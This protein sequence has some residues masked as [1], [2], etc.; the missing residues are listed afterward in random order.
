MINRLVPPTG[1]ATMSQ[2]SSSGSAARHLRTHPILAVVVVSV[3]L[4]IAG[5]HSADDTATGAAPD[6]AA[7]PAKSRSAMSPASLPTPGS[8]VVSAEPADA[9]GEVWPIEP[10]TLPAKVG[11]AGDLPVLT[12]IRTGR[13]HSYERLVLDFSGSFGDVSVGYKRLIRE[14]PTNRVM[15]LPGHAYLHVVVRGVVATWNAVP[16]QQYPGPLTVTP[17]Y[18]T[19]KQV[20][21]AGDFE[22]VLSFGVGLDRVAGFKVSRLTGPDRLVID[23]AERPQW[24]MW[25]EDSLAQARD[26][27]GAADQGHQPWRTSAI[28]VARTYAVSVYGWTQPVVTPVRGTNTYRIENHGLSITVHT[29]APFSATSTNSVSLIAETR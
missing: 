29:A 26:M 3:A 12:A 19:L 24:R 2:T 18:P 10:V 7:T 14:D 27:Q 15:P 28:D 22:A 1:V 9:P 16:H 20:S 11:P 6:S 23:I 5:C 13:H 4:A 21:I 8:D 17:N 25:P